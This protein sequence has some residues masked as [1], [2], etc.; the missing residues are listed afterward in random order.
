[1][2]AVVLFAVLA[3]AFCNGANDNMKGVATVWG[4]GLLSY[5][6]SLILA[7]T[8][9]ALG[10]ILSGVVSVQLVNLFAA[11]SW[12]APEVVGPEL[13]VAAASGAGAGLLVATF[14]GLP[15]STTHALLGGLAGAGLAAAPGQ[16]RWLPLAS[17]ALAPLVLSPVLAAAA[18]FALAHG[19][20]EVRRRLGIESAQCVC[21]G[22]QWVPLP[23]GPA[24]AARVA[25]VAPVLGTG[26][27]ENCRRRYFGR[28]I[29]LS[30]QKVVDVVHLASAA[31]VSFA[32]GLNDTPK[33][34]GIAV[35]GTALSGVAVIPMVA[36]AMAAGALIAGRP[37]GNTLA[38]RLASLATGSGAASNAATA[39]LVIGASRL[40]LPVSTTHVSAGAIA[41]AG[42]WS[43]SLRRPVLWRILG[44]WLLTLPVT[45]VVAALV[46][47]ALP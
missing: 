26:S 20:L 16:V 6:R 31:A 9:T 2:E 3:V 23:A 47:A 8:A 44:S 46:R 1:M 7:T 45:G 36:A 13:M 42:A 35:G 32:R 18:A 14:L 5:R 37:V 40:G 30:A 34:V 24:A 11:Q 27:W 33:L 41:G 29:G 19:G 22:T 10:A 25:T 21:V 12:I 28:V 43:N 17:L 39:L 38:R 4:S 15:V